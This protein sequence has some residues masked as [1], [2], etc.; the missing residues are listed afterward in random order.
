MHPRLIELLEYLDT[1]RASMLGVASRVPVERWRV[2]PAPDRWS[3]AEIC[4][5]LQRVE[6]GVARLVRKRAEQARADGHPA[7]RPDSP[8]LGTRD[9]RGVT[10][11]SQ[12]YEAPA[13]VTP[14]T[15][16]PS[17]E[18]A[19]RLL[20]ESREVLRAAIAEADGLALGSLVHPHPAVGPIDLYE[21]ILF[22]GLHEKRHESQIAEIAMATTSTQ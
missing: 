8:L 3:V 12:R 17:A 5:H 16:I 21:W 1:T 9:R 20:Q 2:R 22:V 4:W 14:P 6:T 10:D 19:Q 13:H 18:E 11:R 7:E 15:D